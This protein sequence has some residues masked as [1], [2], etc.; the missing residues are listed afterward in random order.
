MDLIAG[1]DMKYKRL[2]QSGLRVSPLCLGCM[3][4]G[5]KSQRSWI[6]EIDE[7]RPFFQKASESGI[8]FFDTADT[9]SFGAS[10]EVTGKLIREF[11]P[12]DHAVIATKV[13][14]PA[15]EKPG[16]NGMGLSRKHILEAVDGSLRR[17]GTDYIDLY[18][19]HRFHRGTPIEETMRALDDVVRA[20]KVRY[21]G[22]SSMYAFQFVQ[23][24][25]VAELNGWTKFVSMQNLYNLLW[26]EEERQ[27][28]DFCVQTGVGL[29]PW[30]PLGG[31][32]LSTDWRA[33]EKK[34]SERTRE[35]GF[36]V[37]KAY[38]K[39]ADYKVLDAVIE[40]A[41]RRERPMAQVALAW[42]MSRPGVTAPIVGA[43]KL[44]HLDSAIGALDVKLEPE[45]FKA[46][47]D[48]YTWNRNLG[49]LS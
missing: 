41:E 36:Y 2:G 27:M 24:Q 9:Y 8:N 3:S 6:L 5:D 25:S 22:A 21:I 42:L 1:A 28:N 45:D 4:Y 37:T 30:G 49:L 34:H 33:T 32:F 44:S 19:I 48:C 18:Q 16:P 20:G 29:I 23:M 12:R 35:T 11:M 47:D 43:T 39:P 17:L 46:L 38:E 14:N 10:E 26:R 40:V 7:A 31:G 15:A 13:F